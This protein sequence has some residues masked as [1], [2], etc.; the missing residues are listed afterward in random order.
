MGLKAIQE[1]CQVNGT[2]RD[3]YKNLYLCSSYIKF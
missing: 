3:T 1:I 2:K